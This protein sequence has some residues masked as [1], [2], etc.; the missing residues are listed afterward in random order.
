MVQPSD[1]GHRLLL[2]P[3]DCCPMSASR[4]TQEHAEGAD[5]ALEV[6]VA[7]GQF[8]WRNMLAQGAKLA[9]GEAVALP[10]PPLALLGVSTGIGRGCQQSDRTLADG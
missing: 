6:M 4:T 10:H 3:A 5:L 8:S 9:V 1:S 7:E 2:P